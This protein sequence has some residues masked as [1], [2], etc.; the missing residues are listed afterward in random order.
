MLTFNGTTWSPAA[1]VVENGVENGDVDLLSCASPTFCVA[2]DTSD[3]AF[4]YDG[5][6][7]SGPTK[8]ENTQPS[9]LGP[10]LYSVSCAS[11]TF[12]AAVDTNGNAFIYNGSRWSAPWSLYGGD[13]PILSGPPSSSSYYPMAD[14]FSVSCPVAWD[15]VVVDG[16]GA[17]FTY[18]GS[19]W[20]GPTYIYEPDFFYGLGGHLSLTCPSVNF[21][22]V[23][24]YLAGMLVFNGSSWSPAV[25][26]NH[27]GDP[28][29]DWQDGVVA[30][31]CATSSF[32]AA[33]TEQGSNVYVY[34]G[35]L[36]PPSL[37]RPVIGIAATPD[38][39]GYWLAAADGGVFSFG[40]AGFH[41]SMAGI[42][43][44]A[45]VVSIAATPDGNGYWLAA[46]DGGVFSFGDAG[47]HGSVAGI[48]LN[49]PVVSIAA[50]PDGNGYWL[51]AA[52]G[53]VFSF[54]DAPYF[55]TA[56]TLSYGTAQSGYQPGGAPIVAMAVTRDGKSYWLAS[57]ILTGDR[58]LASLGDVRY[59]WGQGFGPV[60]QIIVAVAATPDGNGLWLASPEG[61]V[62]PFGDA[63]VFG[64]S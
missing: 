41:G 62:Y 37:S 50:T 49:A 17:A 18:D 58:W 5:S 12:C 3:N 29:T 46:A 43:L 14:V 57:S 60:G 28:Y 54:G 25:Q 26:I 20:S 61:A 38:G 8:L 48:C 55:G 40:D 19:S 10:D 23:S 44:N 52:D 45:P 24:G 32:C 36:L 11:P 16:N 30:V 22:L 9:P 56:C 13:A 7:W 63:Q 35:P 47:F 2:L 59:A 21:C 31:S 15:C 1:A 27:L 53:V 64:L 39:N 34:K 42:G 33:L 4:T 6:S 51:A